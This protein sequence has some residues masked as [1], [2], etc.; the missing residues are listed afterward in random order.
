[1]ML[2]IFCC[3]DDSFWSSHQVLIRK[4]R[5]EIMPLTSAIFLLEISL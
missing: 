2:V 3:L 5:A 4:G 1:M